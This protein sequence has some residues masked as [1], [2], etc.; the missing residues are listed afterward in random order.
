MV[1][2]WEKTKEELDAEGKGDS[3]KKGKTKEEPAEPEEESTGVLPTLKFSGV[4]AEGIAAQ[5]RKD[6]ATEGMKASAQGVVE[7]M[8]RAPSALRGEAAARLG[9]AYKAA[10][11]GMGRGAGISGATIGALGAAGAQA[12]MDIASKEA[13]LQTDIEAQRYERD[14]LLRDLESAEIREEQ[15]KYSSLTDQIWAHWN[16]AEGANRSPKA[17]IAYLQD[18][19]HT[20]AAAGDTDASNFIKQQVES[21][22]LYGAPTAIGGMG[23]GSNA[24]DYPDVEEGTDSEGLTYDYW[25]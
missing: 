13:E 23:K 17:M 22:S 4:A 15:E 24:M 6:E 18:L 2:D 1:A 7:A 16:N 20:Y 19:Q 9:E 14:A 8:E 3:E 21:I 5:Q 11:G 10:R 25:N 12:G